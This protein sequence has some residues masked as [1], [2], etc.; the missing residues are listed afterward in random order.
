VVLYQATRHF[1]LRAFGAL[2]SGIITFGAPFSAIG[3]YAAGW[4]HDRTGSYNPLLMLVMAAM[5]IGAL[6]M[7]GTGRVKNDWGVR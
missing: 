6:A 3:P 2:F 4:L 1:G 5:T 7:A